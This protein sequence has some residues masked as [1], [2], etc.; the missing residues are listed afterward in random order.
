M[1]EATP[2]TNPTSTPETTVG[3]KPE[4]VVGEGQKEATRLDFDPANL[5][6][7]LQSVYKSMQA[8]YTRKT[9]QLAEERRKLENQLNEMRQSLKYYESIVPY[10][11]QVGQQTEQ[12]GE[13]SEPA[14]AAPAWDPLNEESVRTYVSYL[15]DQR[16]KSYNEQLQ[17]WMQWQWYINSEALRLSRIY[18]EFDLRTVLRYAPH[19]GYNLEVTAK[20]L[21][22]SPK[23]Y[24]EAEEAA[25]LRENLE[26]LKKEIETLKK[27]RAPQVLGPGPSRP[28]VP[29]PKEKT[30]RSL[31]D[32]AASIPL[33]KVIVSEQ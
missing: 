5:P 33:D 3:S 8:D 13:A 25:T 20:A 15:V 19:Y 21:Y 31:Q 28:V 17:N 23:R 26:A 11:A 2:K 24:K 12:R 30:G 29:M 7:E 6:S 4:G 9:Q 32:I 14:A 16:A 1:P 22:E 10:L 27:S 18:P